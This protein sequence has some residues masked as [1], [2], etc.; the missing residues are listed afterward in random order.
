VQRVNVIGISGSGKSTVA[1]VLADRLDAPHIRL[2]GLRHGRD[3]QE[4]PDEEFRAAVERA[5]AGERWVMDGSFPSVRDL[6]W[7]RA[8]TVV[9]LDLERPAVM[10]QVVQ[11]S[12]SD[13]VARREPVPGNRERIRNWIQ[14]WH[15]IRWAWSRHA[16]A[17]AREEEWLADPRWSHLRVVRLR[18]RD[19]VNRFL[20][21]VRAGDADC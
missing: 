2:D 4:V 10:R 16:A 19:E 17:R 15:P 13:A 21:A 12:L 7:P 11:R 14:P 6:V 9:W 5:A 8:D 3:W 18:S 1:T 20:T